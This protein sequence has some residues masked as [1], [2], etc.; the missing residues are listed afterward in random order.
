M[1]C[2]RIHH[3][4]GRMLMC[5]TKNV[6]FVFTADTKIL[7]HC[8]EIQ[9]YSCSFANL[10]ACYKINANETLQVYLRV[11]CLR[12]TAS[13]CHA[14]HSLTSMKWNFYTFL[15]VFRESRVFECVC[16]MRRGTA[17]TAQCH[18]IH[19]IVNYANW[20]ESFIWRIALQ[21]KYHKMAK[22]FST[23]HNGHRRKLWERVQWAHVFVF[24]CVCS[25]LVTL[26]VAQI[27]LNRINKCNSISKS[28]VLLRS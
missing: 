8:L 23:Q 17:A 11:L 28:C 10:F 27:D 18:I 1:L 2:Y 22:C 20:D 15:E 7:Y 25:V 12:Q 21:R 5:A 24:V 9:S 13:Y 19:I 26:T 4:V 3:F 16:S 6:R 14:T